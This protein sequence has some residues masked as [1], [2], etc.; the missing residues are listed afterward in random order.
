MIVSGVPA[1]KRT[2]RKIVTP[3]LVLFLWDVAVTATYFALTPNMKMLEIPLTLFGT[4]IALFIGFA[5]NASYARWWEARGL[6]GL[7]INASRNLARQ[8][9]TLMDEFRRVHRTAVGVFL[10]RGRY[11][12]DP[13]RILD[14]FDNA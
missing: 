3:L 4:A 5:V 10:D 9:L 14:A 1:F 8:G 6:W 13:T 11:R 7:M 12:R 2:I